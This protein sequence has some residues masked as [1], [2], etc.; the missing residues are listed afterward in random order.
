M[1]TPSAVVAPPLRPRSV[2]LGAVVAMV[3]LIGTVLIV[4]HRP[5]PLDETT[6]ADQRNGFLRGGPALPASVAGV[7]FGG[8]PV[9]LL[10][11]RTLPDRAA[12]ARYSGDLPDGVDFV[13][14]QQLRGGSS[15]GVPEGALLVSDPRQVLSAAVALPTP[16]DRGPGVGYAVVD[17][18]RTVQYS[19]LDP[20]WPRNGFEAAVIATASR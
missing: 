16:N 13:V 12:L 20:S 4:V 9:V 10:F 11:V 7:D 1:A 3:V 15:E 17:P 8:R 19:T 14:V 2:V 18:R 5:G 6:L